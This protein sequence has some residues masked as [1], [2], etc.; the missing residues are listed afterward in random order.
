M[1]VDVLVFCSVGAWAVSRS[2]VP[3]P[4][5][6]SVVCLDTGDSVCGDLGEPVFEVLPNGAARGMREERDGEAVVLPDS[7]LQA[8]PITKGDL[9]S[10]EAELVCGMRKESFGGAGLVVVACLPATDD[11]TCD[12]RGLRENEETTVPC[13]DFCTSSA[14]DRA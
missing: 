9:R 14:S 13:A 8:E 7:G 2:V 4:M 12:L 1:L 11:L 5:V 3:V 10:V 6:C